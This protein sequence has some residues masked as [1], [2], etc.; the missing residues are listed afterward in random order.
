MKY[1]SSILKLIAQ[2][3]YSSTYSNSQSFFVNVCKKIRLHALFSHYGL[4]YDYVTVTA[5]ATTTAAAATTTAAANAAA[6]GGSDGSSNKV[7]SY[8]KYYSYCN[9]Y[10][11][12]T[13]KSL[14]ID[15]ISTK[16]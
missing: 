4:P 13:V 15:I 12:N 2:E 10:F 7:A 16:F 3:I 5:T 1:F 9:K 6:T 11:I 8:F 14:V